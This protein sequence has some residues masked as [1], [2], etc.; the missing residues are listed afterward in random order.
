MITQVEVDLDPFYVEKLSLN[1]ST[2]PLEVVDLRIFPSSMNWT[3]LPIFES[4]IR[5]RLW[6]VWVI[7]KVQPFTYG[8]I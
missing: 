3:K 6:Y 5:A 2:L 7:F 1:G 4:S 8:L